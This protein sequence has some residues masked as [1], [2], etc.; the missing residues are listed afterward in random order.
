MKIPGVQ[1]R[2]VESQGRYDTSGPQ[3]EANAAMVLSRVQQQNAENV[4]NAVDAIYLAESKRQANRAINT[5]N[6]TY[7]SLEIQQMRP[8]NGYNEQ[9]GIYDEMQ[10]ASVEAA[11]ATQLTGMARAMFRENIAGQEVKNKAAWAE[12]NKQWWMADGKAASMTRIADMADAKDYGG[13][14]AEAAGNM[15][16]TPAEQD[17]VIK[18]ID[19]MQVFDGYDLKTKDVDVTSPFQPRKTSALR[20]KIENDGS[21]SDTSRKQLLAKVNQEVI[22]AHSDLN[23]NIATALIPEVG[24]KGAVKYYDQLMLKVATTDYTELGSDLKMHQNLMSRLGQDRQYFVRADAAMGAKINSAMVMQ[25]WLMANTTVDFNKEIPGNIASVLLFGGTI[26]DKGKVEQGIVTREMEAA[27]VSGEKAFPSIYP[28]RGMVTGQESII[29]LVNHGNFMAANINNFLSAQ[30]R[31]GNTEGMKFVLNTLG[32]LQSGFNGRIALNSKEIDS[33]LKEVMFITDAIG[34]H[35]PS[36][37]R[38]LFEES[39]SFSAQDKAARAAGRNKSEDFEAMN[40]AYEDAMENAFPDV[41]PELMAGKRSKLLTLAKENLLTHSWITP[42]QAMQAAANMVARENTVTEFGGGEPRMKSMGQ[43]VEAVFGQGA[44][45]LKPSQ[46]RNYVMESLSKQAAEFK[47]PLPK[48]FEYDIVTVMAPNA[49]GKFVPTK[50]VQPYKTNP[51]TGYRETYGAFIPKY[52]GTVVQESM[53]RLAVRQTAALLEEQEANKQNIKN[54]KAQVAAENATQGSAF[55]GGID[56]ISGGS[57]TTDSEESV[58]RISGQRYLQNITSLP[59]QM[60]HAAD[61]WVEKRNGYTRPASEV[62]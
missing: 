16:L 3:R 8:Q 54:A 62:E 14:R 48:T 33:D 58:D 35:D 20:A 9:E 53:H 29:E 32:E 55:S 56:D 27:L 61:G 12:K 39:K 40:D 50:A 49:K 60:L 25:N 17:N 22:D 13:V 15:F 18:G 26:N 45:T 7:S 46:I 42:E 57:F 31:T 10:T 41:T 51:D 24:L 44:N 47:T 1:Y 2:Q 4:G 59:G 30:A 6:E 37:V 21:L 38:T 5:Y 52:E 36:M 43:T 34:I 19:T 23:L 11:E 28:G